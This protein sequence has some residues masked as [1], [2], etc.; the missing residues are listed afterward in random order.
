MK[1]QQTWTLDLALQGGGSHG[2]FTWG[3]LDALL[4]DGRIYF[5]GVS[6]TSAG[7]MNAAVLAAGFAEAQVGKLNKADAHRMR[8]DLARQKLHDFWHAVGKVGT[9][10]AASPA[11]FAAQ[12]MPWLKPV[13]S[14]AQSN[15]FDINPLR[16]ILNRSVDFEQIAALKDEAWM[17]KLFICA[18]NVRTGQGKVFTNSELSDQVIMASA[19]L[20]ML[21]Q[22]VEIDGEA[23]WDGGYA[24]NPAL[25]PLIYKTKSDD[26]LLVQINPMEIEALPT[27]LSDIQDRANQITFNA[28][29]L[30]ELRAI[31]FVARLMDENKLDGERYKKILM[32]QIDGGSHLATFGSDSKVK[33]DWSFLQQLFMKG[34]EAGE[35]WLEEQLPFVGVKSTMP[36]DW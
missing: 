31:R 18:T 30:S 3:V 4:E 15:P 12:L 9:L 29:L 22:A 24:G 16:N 1:K 10:L 28:G 25:Y 11:N 33:S 2:A 17:P 27:S 5:D 23:Y 21:Y 6:G 36:M 19:C 20:P 7:A 34:R 32:H 35:L 26:I 13:L 14:P 8:C